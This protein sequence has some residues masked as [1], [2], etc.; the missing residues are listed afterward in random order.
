MY[1]DGRVGDDQK[2]VVR[3][4]WHSRA[5]EALVPVMV[6]RNCQ[7]HKQDKGITLA[8]SLAFAYGLNVGFDAR[9]LMEV[10]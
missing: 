10:L 1:V 8:T 4:M 9:R 3:R 7:W 6:V 5:S 2:L